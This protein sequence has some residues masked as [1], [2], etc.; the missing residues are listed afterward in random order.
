MIN[1]D[2]SVFS[3]S[4]FVDHKSTFF[5]RRSRIAELIEKITPTSGK[6]VS[7]SR[8]YERFAQTL[9]KQCSA[10][11][12]LV[13][14][15]SI[16]GEGME[17]LLGYRQIELIDSDISFGPRTKLICDAHDIPFVDNTF[18]G[19]IA[20]AVLE[21]VLDP[22]RCV[23]EIHRVMKSDGLVYAETP[24]MQPVHGSCYDF[25]RFTYL[26]HRRLFRAF[27]E[28]DSGVACGPGV[29]LAGAWKYF[30]WSFSSNRLM[31][32]ALQIAASYTAM[33][34]KYFDPYLMHKD[35]ALD[36]ASGFYFMGRKSHEVLTDRDLLRLYRGGFSQ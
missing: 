2:D 34:W 16:L 17:H 4:D 12:V 3:M 15:G 18:D 1:E 10:P 35:S 24:F 22:Y 9:V 25:T 28:I 33:I 20:Q 6:N 36:A 31:R 19:V 11:R 8:N 23:E 21:H 7:A 29:S 26:G 30:L 32:K 14:G 5:R 27:S 13:I